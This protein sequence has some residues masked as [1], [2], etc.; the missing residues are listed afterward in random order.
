MKKL[1]LLLLMS[2]VFC[3]NVFGQIWDYSKPDKLVTFGVRAGV[4]IASMDGPA[5]IY[6]KSLIDFHVGLKADINIVKSFAVE[7]GLY[8]SGKGAKDPQDRK[9]DTGD[10]NWRC[11]SIQI[12]VLA[13]FKFPVSSSVEIQVKGGG[14]LGYVHV[15]KPESLYVDTKDKM[16]FGLIVGTG[17]S[18]KKFYVG[19]QYEHGLADI[20]NYEREKLNTAFK[21]RNI[22]ISLGYD[23]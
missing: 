16:D 11:P 1:F 4:N 13:D 22:A 10:K 5:G 9:V 7:T 15:E 6:N 12:P 2:V 19:V 21:S 8:Y 23:F 17:V 3:G 20:C 18:I 14:Y